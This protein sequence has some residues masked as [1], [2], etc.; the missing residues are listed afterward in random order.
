M[1]AAITTEGAAVDLLTPAKANLFLEVGGRRADGYH[2]LRTVMMAVDLTDRLRVQPAAGDGIELS[3]RRGGPEH[4]NLVTVAWEV[5]ASHTHRRCGVRVEL[6]KSIPVAA[7]LGGGS[8][9]AAATL[10]GLNALFDARLTA[11]ELGRLGAQVGSDVP[12]FLAGGSLSLCTGRGEQVEPISSRARPIVVL[13]VPPFGCSTAA[14]YAEYDRHPPESAPDAEGMLSALGGPVAGWRGGLYNALEN[15][16]C[17]I[18]P[19]LRELRAALEGLGPLGVVMTGSGSGMVC[20]CRDDRQAVR[21]AEAAAALDLGR[22]V[23]VR[24]WTGRGGM[25]SPRP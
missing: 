14:V 10:I 18:E 5:F 4:D 15:A 11:A 19:R 23:V 13:V 21:L 1:N 16:A 17:R 24:R 20:L 9:D 7:G 25:D 22:A 8:S 12:F 3:V 2:E 6:D